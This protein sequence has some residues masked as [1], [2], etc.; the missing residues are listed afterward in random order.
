MPR[1]S[2]SPYEGKRKNLKCPPIYRSFLAT[3]AVIL[4]MGT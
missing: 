3:F 1:P 2:Q 4:L